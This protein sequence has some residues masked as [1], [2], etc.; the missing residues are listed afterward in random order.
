M[1]DQITRIWRAPADPFH[2]LRVEQSVPTT[3]SCIPVGFM[4]ILRFSPTLLNTLPF[5]DI[6]FVLDSH[7]VL[8]QISRELLNR[9]H[10]P[11]SDVRELRARH[12]SLL[13]RQQAR[14]DHRNSHVEASQKCACVRNRLG[15]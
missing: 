5:N 9:W 1:D 12:I 15:K 11:T 7:A 10:S 3:V 2:R 6:V 4:H 14:L 13:A 8:A